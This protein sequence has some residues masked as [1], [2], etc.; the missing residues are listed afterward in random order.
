[1][2]FSALKTR[3]PY[4]GRA[5]NGARAKKRGR[6][7]GLFSDGCL[8][9]K[10]FGGWGGGGGEGRGFNFGGSIRNFTVSFEIKALLCWLLHTDFNVC[11]Y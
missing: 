11:V 8:H 10:L 9:L 1:M 3:F 6:R 2:E 5:R 7:G 4:F